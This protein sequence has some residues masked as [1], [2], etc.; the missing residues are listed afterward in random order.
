MKV[1]N[2]GQLKDPRFSIGEILKELLRED[3]FDKK[4]ESIDELNIKMLYRALLHGLTPQQ[5]IRGLEIL[6][7]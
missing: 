6:I 5:F 3:K 4:C 7:N 1:V 2:F